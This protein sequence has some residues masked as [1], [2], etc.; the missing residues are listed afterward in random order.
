MS[1]VFLDIVDCKSLSYEL[2]LH[3]AARGWLS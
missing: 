1:G 2:L 3:D